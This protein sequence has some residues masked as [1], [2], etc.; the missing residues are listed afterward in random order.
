MWLEGEWFSRDGLTSELTAAWLLLWAWFCPPFWIFTSGH[1]LDF[2]SVCF[3]SHYTVVLVTKDVWRSTDF[4][5][6]WIHSSFLTIT[7][8]TDLSAVVVQTKPRSL[9]LLHNSEIVLFCTK[10]NQI[11]FQ[12]KKK[13]WW[14]CLCNFYLK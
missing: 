3:R 1:T 7:G 11:F 12:L 4:V 14:F 6:I 2:C 9:S 13:N 5:H 8:V 10:Q